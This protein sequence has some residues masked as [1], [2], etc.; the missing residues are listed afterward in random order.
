MKHLKS[1]PIQLIPVFEASAR[2]MSFRKAA[3]FLHV[4]PP[5]IS[6]QIKA[7]ESYLDTVLFDRKKKQLRLT[8]AG[9]YYFKVATDIMKLH[10][11]GFTEFDRRFNNRSLQVSTPLFIAQELLIPNYLSFKEKVPNTQLRLSTDSEYSDFI[12]D[13]IDVAIRFGMGPWPNLDS[14]LLCKLD[15]SPVCS[16]EYLARSGMKNSDLNHSLVSEKCALELLNNQTIL[17]MHE[18]FNEW[19]QLFQKIAPKEVIVCDSYFSVIKSA[20]AGLGLALGALPAVNRLLNKGKLMMPLNEKFST[21][22]GYWMVTPNRNDQSEIVDSFY[23]WAKALFMTLPI[24][25]KPNGMRY[26]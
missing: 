19:T 3:E 4:T 21:N 26:I 18:D 5:A 11:Q 9:E 24:L 14:R 25:N 22:Y 13:S 17:S 1:P 7:L 12:S 10:Q 16:P 8:V 6:Q 2:L 23:D 20:E 15:I